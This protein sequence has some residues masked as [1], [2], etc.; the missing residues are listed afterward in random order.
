MEKTTAVDRRILAF[1][2]P[3]EMLT[4]ALAKKR[5]VYLIAPFN[6]PLEMRRRRPRRLNSSSRRHSLSILHWRCV[7]RLL[8]LPGDGGVRRLSILHWR[9]RARCLTRATQRRV[10]LSILHWRCEHREKLKGLHGKWVLSI[11]HWRCA[12]ANLKVMMAFDVST[13]NTPLE[14]P[15]VIIKPLGR[16]FTNSVFQY[17]IGDA[18]VYGRTPLHLAVHALSI[19]HWRCINSAPSH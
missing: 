4:P 2:T 13:F 11:L 9:C 10:S 17:S 3:L 8:A 18:D 6:T 15:I 12:V 19:L 1:N 5:A 7:Y 16:S 14:M